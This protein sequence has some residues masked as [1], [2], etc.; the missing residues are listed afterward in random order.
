MCSPLRPKATPMRLLIFSILSA[1]SLFASAAAPQSVA[2]A[3]SVALAAQDTTTA[4]TSNYI[5]RLERYKHLWQSLIPKGNKL[6]F[7]GN[8]GMFS[9]GPTWIYGKNRQWETTLMLG[10][11]PKHSSDKVRLTFTLKEDFVPWSIKLPCRLSWIEFKP[12]ATGIYLNT[13]LSNEFWTSLPKKYPNGYYWFATRLRPNI[14]LGERLEFNIPES[15]RQIAKS[16]CV[17]YEISTCDYFIIQKIHN[18]HFSPE[19]FLTLSLG[20]QFEWL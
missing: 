5:H 12:L 6:Q 7:A 18:K 20:L 13:V 4:T 3:D 19:K 9:L 14:Y 11:I 8:M 2:A 17:F 16:I 15:R 1:I 10:F